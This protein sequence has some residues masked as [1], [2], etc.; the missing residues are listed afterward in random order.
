MPR[1]IADAG[2][3]A[4]STMPIAFFSRLSG[5][6]KKVNEMSFG[7]TCNGFIGPL[8][9]VISACVVA[10]VKAQFLQQGPKL[11]ATGATGMANQG[12]AVALSADGNTALVGA[13]E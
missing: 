10:P 2:E 6:K 13:V 9:C 12:S 4:C 1:Y 8:L 5:R 11:V 7:R 3:N